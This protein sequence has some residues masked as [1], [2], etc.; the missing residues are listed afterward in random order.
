MGCEYGQGY[1][2]GAPLPLAE[3]VGFI[4]THHAG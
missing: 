3:V 1:L 2:F 4:E